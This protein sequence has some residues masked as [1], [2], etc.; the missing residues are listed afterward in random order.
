M[1]LGTPC[2]CGEPLVIVRCARGG[3]VPVVGVCM[4][5]GPVYATERKV[6]VRRIIE[7]VTIKDDPREF[8]AFSD[9][10][11]PR[12][13]EVA[14]VVRGAHTPPR[15]NFRHRLARTGWWR[16]RPRGWSA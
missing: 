5:H 12:H 9:L 11:L 15:F 2:W 10:F 1:T 3:N 7:N 4:E 8:D 13:A 14:G 6:A 16:P